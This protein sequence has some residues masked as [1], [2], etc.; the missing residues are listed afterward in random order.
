[1]SEN[2]HQRISQT[3]QRCVCLS[4]SLVNRCGVSY[5]QEYSIHGCQSGTWPQSGMKVKQV[6]LCHGGNPLLKQTGI[7]IAT[8]A[9]PGPTTREHR[10]LVSIKTMSCGTSSS[11]CCLECVCAC[12]C[13]AIPFILDVRFVDAPTRFTQEKGH[14]GFL[15]LPQSCQYFRI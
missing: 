10:E 3:A 1:M 12:V 4:S 5:T 8:K 15:H 7:R 11:F 14:T 6:T 2:T 9:F 13:V